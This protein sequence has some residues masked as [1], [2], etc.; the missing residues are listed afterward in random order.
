MRSQE[1]RRVWEWKEFVK[2]T[3]Q[4]TLARLTFTTGWT[5]LQTVIRTYTQCDRPDSIS[6]YNDI[7]AAPVQL[8]KKSVVTMCI[9]SVRFGSENEP[10]RVFSFL[11][12]WASVRGPADRELEEAVVWSYLTNYLYIRHFG[13]RVESDRIDK[14]Q[15]ERDC[16]HLYAG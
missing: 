16:L 3:K 6:G 1:W 11:L 12:T 4:R 8:D 9:Q 2:C 15:H 10:F 13:Q 7:F 14:T 5:L